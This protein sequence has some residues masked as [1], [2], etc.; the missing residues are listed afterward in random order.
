MLAYPGPRVMG[1]GPTIRDR[2]ERTS[3]GARVPA[4]PAR[5]RWPD[6]VSLVPVPGLGG[7]PAGG[8]LPGS[9]WR[10]WPFARCWRCWDHVS[11]LAPLVAFSAFLLL[12]GIPFSP[13]SNIERISAPF[14]IVLCLLVLRLTG[15]NEPSGRGLPLPQT[16]PTDMRNG[17]ICI[18]NRRSLVQQRP[19]PARSPTERPRP[20]SGPMGNR[21]PGRRVLQTRPWTSCANSG[22]RWPGC[23]NRWRSGRRPEQGDRPRDGRRRRL[24]ERR[25]PAATGSLPARGSSLVSR[26]R[27]AELVYGGFVLIDGVGRVMKEYASRPYDP[28]RVFT[29]G[30]Y[31]FSGSMFLRRSRRLHRVGPFDPELRACM[32]LDFLLRLGP[33]KDGCNRGPTCRVQNQR[34][35][36]VEHDPTHLSRGGGFR[37]RR[38]AARPAPPRLP[39]CG[40]D[41]SGP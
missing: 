27:L 1:Q 30:C 13:Y 9:R 23:P 20:G 19:V 3:R 24:D 7:S 14:A 18:S 36:Q 10:S 6:P 37:V 39:A 15:N 35:L 21:G 2:D 32:D 38:R 4:G 8:R 25:R 11:S 17:P 40:G 31:I 41:G 33:V 26:T 34:R 28:R 12:W 5:R 22:P 29:H 16:E